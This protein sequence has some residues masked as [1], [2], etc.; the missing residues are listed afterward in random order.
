[1]R[2]KYSAGQKVAQ[3][4]GLGVLG[5]GACVGGTYRG[6]ASA[7]HSLDGELAHRAAVW[8]LGRG[9]YFRGRASHRG[10]LEVEF[11]GIK[12]GNTVGI[13]A[14]FD[15]HGEAVQGLADI[16]FVEVGSVTPLAQEGN[17]KPRVFRLDSDEAVLIRYGFN[18]EG[19]EAVRDRLEIV[20]KRGFGGVLGV[21]LG[22]NKTS[23]SASED[24]AAGVK[25]FGS[26][27]DYLAINISSPNTPGLRSL[28]EK[29]DLRLLIK[30]V[31]LARKELG[32]SHPPPILVKIAPDL[33][34]EDKADTAEVV[35]APDTRVDG[36][37]FSNTTFTRPATLSSPRRGETG[38]MSCAPL[39]TLSTTTIRD[40]YRLT[41]GKLPIVGVGFVSSGQD[42]WEKVLAGTS[43]VQL[44]SALVYQGPSVVNRVRREL[45][46]LLDFSEFS[47]IQEAVGAE[48]RKERK[49]E[50]RKSSIRLELGKEGG[51]DKAEIWEVY[52]VRLGASPLIQMCQ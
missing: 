41:S 2:I 23:P 5:G 43:L 52:N 51:G 12:F 27:A 25:L 24:Y 20:K 13:V 16:G 37:V 22:K 28:Q 17:P 45:A 10:E 48:H 42:A 38:G 33:T 34:D 32:L 3:F 50:R 49:K 39:T 29:E 47:N 1:M 36:L 46:E 35:M 6:V 21:N 14:G 4:L 9:F 40:M 26:L 11:W 19:L 31:L 7:L 30:A 44:Y 8:A 18:S 15:K